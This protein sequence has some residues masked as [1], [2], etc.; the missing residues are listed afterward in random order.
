MRENGDQISKKTSLGFVAA[1]HMHGVGA[2]NA[3]D[4]SIP[5]LSFR[6]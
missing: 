4:S 6:C 5:S 3:L 1:V 2:S